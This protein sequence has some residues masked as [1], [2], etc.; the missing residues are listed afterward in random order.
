MKVPLIT[1]NKTAENTS[2]ESHV[3]KP[4]EENEDTQWILTG[5]EYSSDY[6]GDGPDIHD[7]CHL[8]TC[9][10]GSTLGSVGSVGKPLLKVQLKVPFITRNKTAENTSQEYHVP[11]PREEDEDPQWIQT[12]PQYSSDYA[13]D[14]PDSSEEYDPEKDN[15]SKRKR[16]KAKNNRRLTR[17]R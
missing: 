4:R 6:T 7:Q 3:P 2:Q 5:P 16:E 15:A 9:G 13:G 1:G 17:K 11:K 12:G 10:P 14:G 8:Y